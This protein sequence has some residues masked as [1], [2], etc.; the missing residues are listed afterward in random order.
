M[1]LGGNRLLPFKGNGPG[2]GIIGIRFSVFIYPFDDSSPILKFYYPEK[3]ECKL[4]EEFF[5]VRVLQIPTE[6]VPLHHF[7]R[8]VNQSQLSRQDFF[9]NRK[10]F[11]GQGT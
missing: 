7:N 8:E 9:I 11:G 10:N 2:E 1:N 6:E 4:K 3:E 5:W